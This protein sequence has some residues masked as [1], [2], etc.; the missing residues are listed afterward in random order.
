M[1]KWLKYN[2]S[3]QTYSPKTVDDVI[4]DK[5]NTIH[6]RIYNDALKRAILDNTELFNIHDYIENEIELNDNIILLENNKF[7]NL[8]DYKI[9][10]INENSHYL[11]PNKVM[12]INKRKLYNRFILDLTNYWNY[13]FEAKNHFYNTDDLITNIPDDWYRY[14]DIINYDYINGK[15]TIENRV[16]TKTRKIDFRKIS[17][18]DSIKIDYQLE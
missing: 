13:E 7:V 3:Q 6:N 18:N 8:S 16:E 1:S 15:A 9:S 11:L 12:F 14:N 2:I 4:T 10:E 17:T 5:Y